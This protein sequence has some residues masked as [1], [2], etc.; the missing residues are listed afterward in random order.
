MSMKKSLFVMAIASMLSACGGGG[1]SST[2][3]SSSS[4]DPIDRYIGTWSDKCNSWSTDDISTANGDSVSVIQVLKFEK[5]SATKANYSYTI[6]V[7]GHTDTQCTGQPIATVVKTGLNNESLSISNATAT[8]TSSFGTNQ[9][10]YLGAQKLQSETVDKM[11]IAEAKLS[12]INANVSVG[13]A[14]VNTG[15]SQ[16]AQQT[17]EVLAKFKSSSQVLFNA[18]ENGVIPSQ[19]DDDEFLVFTKQ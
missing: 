14:I 1:S 7:Y 11:Q 16:F 19:M 2:S 6:K 13:G 9:L 10:T 8:M 4:T 15:S 17:V 18:I 5:A 12:N 3:D